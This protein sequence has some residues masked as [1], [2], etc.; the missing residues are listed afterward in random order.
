MFRSYAWLILG[1]S[2][3]APYLV[4]GPAT[5][6][7]VRDLHFAEALFYAH[8]GLFFEALERLD[9]ELGQYYGLDEPHLDSLHY[10]INHAEFAVGD[11]ELYYRMHHRA[12]RAIRA[13]LEAD[14]DDVIRNEAAF[15]LARLHF[16]KD[17]PEEALHALDRIRGRVPEHVRDDVEFLR[18]NIYMARGQPADA[19]TVL[20][21]LQGADDLRGYSAYN[22][23]IAL[24]Q[25]GQHHEALQ[26]L[27]R[28]GQV[29]GGDRGTASIRDK[30]NLV[31]GTI[32]SEGAD[33][34]RA[35]RFLER[36]R[37]EGPFSNRALLSAGWAAVA[38]ENYE[39]ALV[40]WS[41]L[42][43]REITD[44]TVQEALLAVPYAYGKLNVHGRAAL[45]YARALQSFGDE[46]DRVDSSIRS[47]RE[48]KFLAALVREEIRQ[49]RN[50]VVN[51][52]A[53]P[54]SPETYY[55]TT[56]LA[57]HDFQSSL[58]NY[59][60]LEDLRRK[61]E[62]WHASL[63]AFEDIV[64]L[65]RQY[66]EPLLPE[67]DARFRTL[68]SQIRLRKAQRDSLD[69][70][71]HAML[72]APRPELLATADE[73]MA[74]ERIARV[75]AS[76][77]GSDASDDAPTRQRIQRL[78]GLLVWDLHTEYHE[79]L[80]VAHEHLRDVNEVVDALLAQ[81][82]AYVRIRQAASHSYEGYDVDIVRN[83]ARV[84]QAQQAVTTMMA[85]QGH[86]L[87][88]MAI[89]ELELRRQRLEVYQVHARFALADSYD[90]ASAALAG[91]GE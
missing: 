47:I 25:G 79:R 29:R 58:Q 38:A 22:L 16:Q 70:R 54:E 6:R 50:W 19:I 83:R 13:V 81:Y 89:R 10:H 91:D 73:R 80:T 26:Q 36:V 20:R 11:F 33:F 56:L 27:D 15:R 68:D 52:R 18:A 49:D 85:R 48:G 32:L 9:A 71:L 64:E 17:Q 44:H 75:E 24:L 39:R 86:L 61:L 41:M 1:L 76:L 3:S 57:S 4:A 67:I 14:V 12:G 21:R 65:R 35:Q 69:D 37:L 5:V 60:D 28:A 34:E 87:S 45:M 59:L 31:L 66:Y 77:H 30:S 63:D 2:L 90:R 72:T 82:D 40:P 88:L 53:L 78:R 23:G 62:S 51:L 42:V 46:L 7:D 84:R 74:L 43:E 55:L 8:Q